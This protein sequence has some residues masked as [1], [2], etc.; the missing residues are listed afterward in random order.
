MIFHNH[1]ATLAQR[2]LHVLSLPITLSS[3]RL[4]MHSRSVNGLTRNGE[5]KLSSTLEP[6]SELRP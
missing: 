2:T 3:L 5:I 4:H 1:H 6:A